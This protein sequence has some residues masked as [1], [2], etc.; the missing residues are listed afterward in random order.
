MSCGNNGARRSIQ[1]CLYGGSRNRTSKRTPVAD[2]EDANFTAS[3]RTICKRSPAASKRAFSLKAA[4]TFGDCSTI[5]TF[6]A[7]REAASKPS[8]PLPAKRS[9]HDRPSRSCPS[10]L[11]SVSR[12]RS[13][14]GRRPCASGKRKTR[15]RHSPPMMRTVFKRRPGATQ[16]GD[17][18]TTTRRRSSETCPRYCS[19]P[20]TTVTSRSIATC[21]AKASLTSAALTFWTF[22]A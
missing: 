19:P 20:T 8:A 9:R 13:G 14:V 22:S 15:R 4:A 12:T 5:T 7:P 11:K 3:A 1:P 17:L 2:S 21:R 6:A 10:Q 16:I 18:T